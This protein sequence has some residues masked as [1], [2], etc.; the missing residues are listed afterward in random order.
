VLVSARRDTDAARRFFH[1]ALA[2]PKVTPAEV[3]TD[4][5]SVYPAVLDE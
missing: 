5:A 2:V 1:R 4:T 3:V